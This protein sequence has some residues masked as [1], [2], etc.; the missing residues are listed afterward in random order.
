MSRIFRIRVRGELLRAHLERENN[1][2]VS[3]GELREFLN[4]AGFTPHGDEW[5]VR[6]ADLGILDPEEVIT[7]ELVPNGFSTEHPQKISDC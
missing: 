5:L 3:E 6:E 4:N 1:E 2:F 7:I